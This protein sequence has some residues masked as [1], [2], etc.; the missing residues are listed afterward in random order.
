MKSTV[1][2]NAKIEWTKRKRY[3]SKGTEQLQNEVSELVKSETE[4][5]NNILIGVGKDGVQLTVLPVA[6]SIL[7]WKAEEMGFLVDVELETASGKEMFEKVNTQ[8]IHVRL[9][10]PKY[11]KYFSELNAKLV[12]FNGTPDMLYEGI[13]VVGG[14]KVKA[15]V[16]YNRKGLPATQEEIDK[17]IELNC[18]FWSAGQHKKNEFTGLNMN[19]V[20]SVEEAEEVLEIITTG[21]YFFYK[22]K[23][24]VELV[25]EDK[26]ATLYG[27]GSHVK[28]PSLSFDRVLATKYNKPQENASIGFIVGATH[29]LNDGAAWIRSAYVANKYNELF[30]RNYAS[31]DFIGFTSQNRANSSMKAK[32][33]AVSDSTQVE[34]I[35]YHVLDKGGKIHHFTREEIANDATLKHAIMSCLDNDVVAP[36]KKHDLIVISDNGCKLP[37]YLVDRNVVKAAFDPS[38]ELGYNQMLYGKKKPYNRGTASM[39][40]LMSCFYANP[41]ATIEFLSRHLRDQF[42]N[43]INDIGNTEKGG[44]VSFEL[45]E[46]DKFH[47]NTVA[48]MVAPE[49]SVMS[50]AMFEEQA[51]DIIQAIN[52]GFDK[53]RYEGFDGGYFYAN[54][55]FARHF[56]VQLLAE[57]EVYMQDYALYFNRRMKKLEVAEQEFLAALEDAQTDAEKANYKKALAQIYAEVRVLKEGKVVMYRSPKMSIYEVAVRKVVTFEE[58]VKRAKSAGFTKGQYKAVLEMYAN[59]NFGTLMISG[60]KIQNDLHS[61]QD[62]DM[63]GFSVLFDYRFVLILEDVEYVSLSVTPDNKRPEFI[64]KADLDAKRNQLRF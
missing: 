4:M 24:G 7:D 11:A 27:R 62:W 5:V 29:D 23:Y 36:F 2:T 57:D 17:A 3:I 55:D 47:H 38:M 41:K 18:V 43:K 19:T 37:D 1:N 14:K 12:I 39:Q 35:K 51:N 61:G 21:Q 42:Q 15:I 25:W 31:A 32:T 40:L 9:E 30:N 48:K 49:L 45:L 10:G 44:F 22:N 50:K 64:T 8:S 16:S 28:S 52:R 60:G 59:A 53:N 54:L 33:E 46:G 63:D 20:D 56:G 58:I 13:V 6:K 34:L 26:L